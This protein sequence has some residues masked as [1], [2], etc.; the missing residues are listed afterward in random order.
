LQKNER[1]NISESELVA[2]K[3]LAKDLLCLTA[4]QIAVA[5]REGSL[6]EVEYEE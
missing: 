3:K 2:L 6:V 5:I 1:A 4:V